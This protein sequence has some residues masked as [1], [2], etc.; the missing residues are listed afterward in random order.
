MGIT[1][2]A[3]LVDTNILVRLAHR[4]DPPREEPFTVSVVSQSLI[5]DGAGERVAP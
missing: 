4:P 5:I 2:D 1:T 3:W